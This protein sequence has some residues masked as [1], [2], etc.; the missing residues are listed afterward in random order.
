MLLRILR[1]R[2]EH[3]PHSYGSA[4]K[5]RPQPKRISPPN[6]MLIRA[7]AQDWGGPIR[8]LMAW[9]KRGIYDCNL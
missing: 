3:T 8:S 7:E 5:T 2:I 4:V 9:T 6:T 1:L